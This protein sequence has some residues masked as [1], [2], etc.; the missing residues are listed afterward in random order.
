MATTK[1]KGKVPHNSSVMPAP[2]SRAS[3][4]HWVGKEQFLGDGVS[5]DPAILWDQPK[6]GVTRY[7]GDDKKLPK[8]LPII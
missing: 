3:L 8:S 4:D 1:K 2:R 7:A 5:S 6:V